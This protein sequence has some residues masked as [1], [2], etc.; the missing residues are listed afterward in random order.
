M[1]LMPKTAAQLG[2]S[3]SLRPDENVAGGA[4]YLDSLLTRYHDNLALALAAYNAGPAAVDRWHG[5]PPYRET[6][7]YVARIIRDF[8]ASVRNAGN[9]A[10]V[11]SA[12]LFHPEYPVPIR[13]PQTGERAS[14]PDGSDR[15]LNETIEKTSAAKS[16][17]WILWLLA[18]IAAGGS[19]AVHPRAG[20]VQLDGLW[21]A[22]ETG[23][24]AEV[25]HCDRDDLWRLCLAGVSLGDFSAAG[26]T[27]IAVRADWFAGH[28]L[29]RSR[30]FWPARRPGAA[31]PGRAASEAYGWFADRRLYGGADVRRRR[32]WL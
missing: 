20:T 31:L 7:L 16:K 11:D 14:Q 6:R 32:R 10:T 5:V 25:R 17:R 23:R 26:E 1:Q 15:S 4:S 21:A 22:V 30:A 8:N 28:R 24:L 29:Y 9:N 19:G 13:A 12:K 2:V 18:T 3:D 27:S